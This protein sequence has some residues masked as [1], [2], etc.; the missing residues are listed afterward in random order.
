MGN[1]QEQQIVWLDRLNQCSF[2]GEVSLS[3]DELREIASI[4][5]VIRPSPEMRDLILICA[6]NCAYHYYDDDGF[7]KHFMKLIEEPNTGVNREH[8]GRLIEGQLKERGLA[9]RDSTGPFR[10]VGAILEQ[11]A[12]S[13]KHIA[14][15]ATIVKELKAYYGWEGLSSLEY[16]Q[17]LTHISRVLC[18]RYLKNYL[19]DPDGWDFVKQ[20]SRLCQLLENGVIK[21]DELEK[22][23]GYQPHFWSELLFVIN[24]ETPTPEPDSHVN[25]KKP[26]L[27]F[28][29]DKLTIGLSLNADTI[30]EYPKVQGWANPITWLRHP[31]L[32][33]STYYGYFSVDGEIRTEWSLKGWIPDGSPALFNI[34]WSFV[35]PDN[36][37][38]PGTY[39]LLTGNASDLKNI[40][41][42]ALGP[43]DLASDTVNRAYLVSL[44]ED[45]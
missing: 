13:R 10:Y 28:N 27:M 3:V 24:Q 39:Y 2:A 25:R 34:N 38:V 23:I 26:Y 1:I 36:V 41:W 21:R 42:E 35:H 8:V 43:V 29:P 33:N 9:K 30:V 15:F 37:I 32:F 22:L 11:C 45:A 20:V 5:N 17:Y 7:W 31:S 44:G 16:D 18:S 14:S 40:S 12:V 4:I 6:V 19:V